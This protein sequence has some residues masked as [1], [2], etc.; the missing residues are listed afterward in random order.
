MILRSIAALAFLAPLVGC[1][2]AS[3]HRPEAGP[4]AQRVV[5]GMIRAQTEGAWGAPALVVPGLEPGSEAWVYL[6]R[7]VR[8]ERLYRDT[9]ADEPQWIGGTVFRHAVTVR[10]PVETWWVVEVGSDGA[11]RAVRPAGSRVSSCPG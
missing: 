4:D 5:P 1:T 8:V 6:R 7:D 3:P 10:T 9:Y 2:T 11:V